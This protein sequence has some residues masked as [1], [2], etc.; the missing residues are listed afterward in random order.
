MDHT[1]VTDVD[2]DTSVLC[3]HAGEPRDL[4]KE[5]PPQEVRWQHHFHELH[6]QT[7]TSLHNE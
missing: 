4:F 3:L 5:E 7:G 2:E 6:P 1:D